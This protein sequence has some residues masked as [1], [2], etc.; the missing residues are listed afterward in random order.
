MTN[1]WMEIV[2]GGAK[3]S[4][5]NNDSE[6]MNGSQVLRA[7]FEDCRNFQANRSGEICVIEVIVRACI[8]LVI[9]S[10]VILIPLVDN[11]FK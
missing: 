10:H 11:E 5:R 8:I 4:L 9:A 6:T 7:T 3:I 2:P 1:R